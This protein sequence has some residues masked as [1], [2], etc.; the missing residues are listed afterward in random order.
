MKRMQEAGILRPGIWRITSLACLIALAALRPVSAADGKLLKPLSID[1]VPV[2]KN[3]HRVFYHGFSLGPSGR[4]ILNLKRDNPWS[5]PKAG[6]AAEAIDTIRILGMRFD[7]VYEEPD[8]ILTTKR[9]HFDF[10]DYDDFVAEYKH[11]IDP[12]PHNREY[13]ESHLNALGIYYDFVSKGKV[14]LE[15]DVYPQISDSVYHLPKK[16]G[17]YGSQRPDSGLTEFWIDC[18]TLVDTTEP[19]IHFADYDSYF[20]FHAGSDRQ[21]D[22]GFPPTPSDL[23]TGYIFFLGGAGITV[24]RVMIGDSTVDSFLIRDAMIV[25]EVG[26]QDGRAVALNAVIAHEFGHQLGLVD[27]YRTDNFFTRVGDFALMDNN[28]FGTGVDFGF[29][30]VGRVFGVMPVYPMA[31]SRAYLGFVE[32]VEFKKGTSIELAAAEMEQVGIQ[33]AKIPISEYEYYL[34]ENRQADFV[35]VVDSFVLADPVTSVILGPCDISRNLTGEYDRLSP[36]SG[37]LIWRVDEE[38]ALMDYDG[39]GLN[40]FI[41][42]DLQNYVDR[43]FVQLL[44]ADGLINFGGDYYSGYGRQ[45]DM[46]YAGNNTSFTPNTNPP[47]L[48]HGGTN[49]HVYVTNISESEVIMSFDLDRDFA[50]EN[51]PQRVGFP[52]YPLSP[53]AADLNSDGEDEIIIASGR[54]IVVLNQDGTDFNEGFVTY[55]DTSY[56]LY[57]AYKNMGTVSEYNLPLFARTGADITAGPVVGDFGLD[58]DTQYVAVGADS[59]LYVFG[60][61]DD[62]LDG[63]AEPFFDNPLPVPGKVYWLTFGKHLIAGVLDTI[64][65]RITLYEIYKEGIRVPASPNIGEKEFFGSVALDSGFAVTAGDSVGVRL[66][67]IRDA[68]TMVSLDLEG[69]YTFGPVA[70]SLDRDSIPEVIVAA[71]D[72]RVKAISID[73]YFG[74]PT[75]ELFGYAQLGEPITV[76]PI[77]SDVDRDGYPDIVLGGRNKIYALDRNMYSL[78]N[79]PILVDRGFPDDVVAFSPVTGD[80]NNDGVKDVVALSSDGSCYAFSSRYALNEQLLYGFPLAAGLLGFGSPLIYEKHNGGGLGFVGADGWFYSYDVGFDSASVDWPMAGGGP[81]G[82]FYFPLERLGPVGAAA[83]VLP[84]DKFFCYPNP[85]L[86]GR[87]TIRY[88]VGADA[89]VT[90]TF[91]DMSGKKVD[92]EFDRSPRGGEVDEFLWDGSFLP[93]GVYRCVLQA[94]FSRGEAKSSFTDI[95]IVK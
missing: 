78:L 42:N 59:L 49:T 95:A 20:L 16:M 29:A 94:R 28:G 55:L 69:D 27:L 23:F 47:A 67:Y 22:I 83:E 75:L 72:G 31:W 79:F 3:D 92:G 52:I 84:D 44:E 66:Y 70:A 21:N 85:S 26:S 45:E 13:F 65:P 46:Y 64:Q 43:P 73:Y 32:P 14:V 38:V 9:G 8:D 57:Y 53:I 81:G 88:F 76:N 87:T 80:I 77:I 7:F 61:E 1:R 54:N 48:G 37:M 2:D 51:F 68:G 41:D 18:I 11:P 25:P 4:N 10:R 74:E 91:Y 56:S 17:H 5:L 90:F 58:N 63:L 24:D 50:S 82:S 6:E 40:N 86:D 15:Y 89:S 34:L 39:D 33:V 30:E 93:T 19:D 36:G 35:G 62:N 60:L 12:S 71:P